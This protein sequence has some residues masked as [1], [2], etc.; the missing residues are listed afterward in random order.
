M[1][2]WERWR[3]GKRLPRPINERTYQG[4]LTYNGH[5]MSLAA[6]MATIQVMQE[7]H[8]VERAAQTGQ[9]MAD[10]LAELVER[11]PSVGDVRSIGLFGVVELVRNRQTKEPM[12][13]FNGSSAEMD[14]LRKYLVG[15]R[16]FSIYSLA[17][18]TFDPAAD[19]HSRAVARGVFGP[20]S[21]A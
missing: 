3:C 19:H 2:H 18:G 15:S 7:E 16:R 20:R 5:P 6:A 4:G 21:R 10:M 14:R 8:L 12:A 1:P 17:Y 13:P 9:V 11:H